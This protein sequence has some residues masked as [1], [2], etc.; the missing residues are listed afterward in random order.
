MLNVDDN[1]VNL[2]STRARRVLG[3]VKVL[4]RHGIS[5][6]YRRLLHREE[7]SFAFRFRLILEEL[8]P[9]FVKFGQVMSTRPDLLPP[10]YLQEL[11][12]L[13][14]A[15]TVFDPQKAKAI[16]ERELGKPWSEFFMEFYPQPTASASLAQVHK[17]VLHS[18]KQVAVKVRRP[19]IVKQIEEDMKTLH[20]FSVILSRYIK[21]FRRLRLKEGVSEFRRIIQLE[22]DFSNEARNIRRLRKAFSNYPRVK[23]PRVYHSSPSLLV[24]E[25][26]EGVKVSNRERLLAQG[27]HPPQLA[28][29][30]SRVWI[31]QIFDKGL[32]HADPHPGNIL[33]MSRRKIGLV[34]MGV[35]GE[36]DRGDRKSLANLFQAVLQRDSGQ[37]YHILTQMKVFH[38]NEKNKNLTKE[39]SK[40][41]NKYYGK[42][43]REINPGNLIYEIMGR[44]FRQYE[45]DPPIRF[46]TLAKTLVTLEA[47]CEDLDPDFDWTKNLRKEFGPLYLRKL[48]SLNFIDQ[49]IGFVTLPQRVDRILELMEKNKGAKVPDYEG[50]EQSG[51]SYPGW[52]IS[53]T[54][55]L[56]V[57]SL[58]LGST[59]LLIEKA[60]PLWKG[61]SVLGLG[62]YLAGGFAG[63]LL[64]TRVFISRRI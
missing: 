16:V 33:I 23:I 11:R 34:D 60:G 57:F 55:G 31:E 7:R 48:F 43:L 53:L 1:D 56:I 25:W 26:L 36:L 12:K 41:L 20:Y 40:L 27:Y 4:A 5:H 30:I 28:R 8:G 46:I 13:Q 39:I 2:L 15:A 6:L 19:N 17:A 29:L 64:L 58:I 52:S 21:Y 35:I 3:V 54:S 32:F 38:Q 59:L 49:L 9:L 63:L 61:I 14:D 37:I 44:L 42:K 50:K 18:G 47:V 10:D 62:G 45:I 51:E 24:L 22:V